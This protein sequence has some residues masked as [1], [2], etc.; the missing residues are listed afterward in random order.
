LQA[1]SPSGRSRPFHR[2]ADGLV[3][4]EGAAFV[5]LKRLADAI[6]AGDPSSA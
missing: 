6:A 3:P 4:G 2:E 1:L 5:V